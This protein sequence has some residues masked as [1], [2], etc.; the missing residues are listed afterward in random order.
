MLN[1]EKMKVALAAF[2]A[3]A[4]MGSA[5]LVSAQVTAPLSVEVLLTEAAMDAVNTSAGSETDG[6]VVNSAGTIGYYFDSDF[7]TDDWYSFALPSGTPTLFADGNQLTA[8]ATTSVS[9]GDARIDPSG[10]LWT[11]AFGSG[12]TRIVKIPPAGGASA[13]I[14]N[15]N[16]NSPAGL[17]VDPVNSLLIVSHGFFAGAGNRDVYSYPLASGAGA[18]S[19]TL[20]TEAALT[21]V[22]AGQTAYDGT[23]TIL[24]FS[25]TVQPNDGDLILSHQGNG[26]Q[27]SGFLIRVTSGGVG[28][29]FVTSD[30]I[31][32]AGGGTP[33]TDI[34]DGLTH[35]TATANGSVLVNVH[36]A[37]AMDGYIGLIDEAGTSVTSLATYTQV[38]ASVDALGTTLA[39][40]ST[41]Y[42]FED[43][44]PTYNID[45]NGNYYWFHQNKPGGGILRLKGIGAAQTIP[46][47]LSGF[48]IE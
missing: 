34:L 35:V 3:M 17:A 18:S 46:V 21:A 29:T 45:A 11:T 36:D 26:T 6:I 8:G 12:T 19:T 38:E 9:A 33:G 32:T 15:S 16:A 13:V 7:G 25:M 10:N 41:R 5:S 2:G 14:I 24:P 22:L 1:I 27:P 30:A 23:E 48:E 28:S 43:F 40:R 39:L 42:F 4:I 44:K 47:E 37:G 31:V 20:I